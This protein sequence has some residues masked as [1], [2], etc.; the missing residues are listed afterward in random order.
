[1][2]RVDRSFASVGSPQGLHQIVL[3]AKH[4]L[5][6]LFRQGPST[7]VGLGKPLWNPRSDDAYTL[8]TCPAPKG[9]EIPLVTFFKPCMTRAYEYGKEQRST[10]VSRVGLITSSS[11]RLLRG[12]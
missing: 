6:D 12:A 2:C 10:R 7:L 5:E 1:M 4:G 9:L 11:I 3:P 8:W